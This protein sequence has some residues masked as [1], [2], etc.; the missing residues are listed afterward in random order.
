MT[1]P[2]PLPRSPLPGLATAGSIAA[3]AEL[4]HQP[5]GVGCPAAAAQGLTLSLLPL[6]PPLLQLEALLLRLSSDSSQEVLDTLLQQ[7]LPALLRRLA[8]AELLTAAL[9][10]HVS[11]W[12]GA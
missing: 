1:L 2:L 11:H 3:A 5:G 4:P 6:P 9:V 10:P 12:V 8:D 7:A